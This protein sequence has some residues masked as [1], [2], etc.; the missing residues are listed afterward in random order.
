MK[1]FKF[2]E[3]AAIEKILKS[4]FV[5]KNN[6]TNTIYSLAK[7]NY[8]VLN[9][10]DKESYN[11]ILKYVL[12]NCENIYEESIYSDIENC[13]KAA[14]K[15]IL[16][17][18]KEVCITQT[19]LDIIRSLNDIKQEKAIF[20]LLAVSKYFNL[21]NDKN[22]D[23]AFL[24]NADICKMA[25]ITI[26]TKDRDEFMQFAY[27]KELLFRHTWCNSTIKKLTFIS[28][29]EDD[30]VVL[31]L[32]E[33]DFKDLAYVY[34]AYIS[35]SKF[36]RCVSCGRWMRVNKQDKR[37]CTECSNAAANTE[38]KDFF[39][40][41]VCVDCGKSIYVPLLNTKTCR[42]EECQDK[43]N[44]NSNR[45]RQQRWYNAHIKT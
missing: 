38:E 16:A 1:Q 33:G 45:E 13:I 26:P 31:R 21:L 14:K 23:A 19:E 29:D 25:R 43:A 12:S 2:N 8:H 44:E 32:G 7:Y 11:R 3:Q 4:N 35:P 6:V 42:C 37:L 27:D 9:L 40:T 28:H 5:D 20:V 22:Y 24:T 41:V 10:E 39:K 18:I 17:T 15:H 36:R 34:L 30:N